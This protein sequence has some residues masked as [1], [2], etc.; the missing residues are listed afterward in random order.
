MRKIAAHYIFPINDKPIKRGLLTLSDSGEILSIGQLGEGE[1]ESVEFYNGI[2]C[3]GFVNA[4]CHLELS[5]MLGSVPKHTGIIGFIEHIA[6]YRHEHDIAKQQAAILSADVA[7]AAE[8]I[9][10]VGDISNSDTSFGIKASSPIFYHNFIEVFAGNP[11]FAH[12]AFNDGVALTAKAQ[13]LG[14]TATLTPHAPYSMSDKLFSDT[15]Q[16]AVRSGIISIHN[17]ECTEENE[18]FID[19]SGRFAG[20]YEKEGFEPPRVIGKPSI[21]RLLEQLEAAVRLLLIHNLFTSSEDYDAVMEKNSNT[22]W[23]L[24]PCSNLYIENRMPPVA[25]LY[26][27]GANVAIGTDSLSSNEQLSMLA[28]LKAI[29]THFPAVPLDVL[30]LWATQGGAK[31]LGID[32]CVGDFTVGKC[33]GVVLVEGIDFDNMQLTPT[34]RAGMLVPAGVIS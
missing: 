23:V 5:S 21:F 9:V 32:H 34:A 14:L 33:P 11:L 26:H 8:G 25:M 15:V 10:A 29:A 18:Y 24:C 12:K 20:L 7:M 28:E 16:E 13:L 19:G 27:K 22:S 17:Q 1:E 31:A 2:L 30:L 3:P 6:M 4:H